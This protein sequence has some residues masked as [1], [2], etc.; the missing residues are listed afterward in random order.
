MTSKDLLT[1]TLCR[2]RDKQCV[3]SYKRLVEV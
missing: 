2:L 3:G 1:T